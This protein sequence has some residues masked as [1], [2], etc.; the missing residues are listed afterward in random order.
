MPIK[1]LT[2]SSLTGSTG[3]IGTLL[4]NI[5]FLTGEFFDHLAYSEMVTEDYVA[6]PGYH[7]F[8]IDRQR[9]IKSQ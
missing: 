1:F 5:D 4:K 7:I 9:N 3:P 2:L 6:V 8:V